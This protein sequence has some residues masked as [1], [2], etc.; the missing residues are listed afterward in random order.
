MKQDIYLNCLDGEE[1]KKGKQLHIYNMLSDLLRYLCWQYSYD[2]DQPVLIDTAISLT[3]LFFPDGNYLDEAYGLAH[4]YLR[5]AK[6]CADD[7]KAEEAD[8]CFKEAFKCAHEYDGLK[9]KHSYTAPL[10]YL[11]SFDKNDEAVTG[12][13]TLTEDLKNML[14]LP[15]YA[16]LK[17]LDAYKE[18]TK[19]E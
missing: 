13:T 12:Q 5:K 15:Y 10:F 11:V 8:E 4:L 2:E 16:V 1:Q 18:M 7:K 14:E 6:H 9:G 19:S 3:K 17:N